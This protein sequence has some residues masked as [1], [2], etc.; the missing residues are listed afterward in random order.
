M[1][2]TFRGT[3]ARHLGALA[4]I[5]AIL[6]LPQQ[7]VAAQTTP[8]TGRLIGRV[9]DAINGTPLGDVGVQ[10]VGT[11]L[12]AITGADGRYTIAGVPAGTV[13]IHARRIGFQAKTVTAIRL[14]AGETLEQNVALREA[15][16][17]LT[18]V[19]VTAAA[20]RGT[21]RE[22][23]NQ[24]REATGIVNAVTA[25]QIA[26][27][28]D[29][30]AASAVQR[31]TGVTLQD[32]R[33]VYVRGMGE[34]Y[35]T[36]S[37]NGARMPSPEPEKKVVP[38][39]LFP[40]SLLR[41]V[42]T[43]KT[44][45]PDQPGD[46]SGAQVD[47]RT[48]EF[49]ARRTVTYSMSTG[50]NTRATGRDV[51][52]AP[53]ASSEWFAF[54]GAGRALPASVRAAG[55]FIGTTYSQAEINQMIG[56]FRNSWTPIS[57]SGLPNSS[58]GVSAGGN[59]P[60]FGRQIGY[61]GSFTYSLS[62]EIQDDDYRAQV[63]LGADDPTLPGNVF[64]GT[65]GR[66]GVQW[67]GLINLSTFLGEGTLLTFNNTFNRTADSEA[68]VDRGWDENIG[69]STVFERSTLRYIER[70]V[71]SHQ[72]AAEHMLGER[73]RVDWAL[74]SSAVTRAEPDRSD[75]V[76]ASFPDVENGGSTPFLLYS[77]ADAGARRTFADLAEDAWEASVNYR[78]KL[79]DETRDHSVKLGA[80]AR[81]TDR[82]A[83]VLQ[84]A[85][86]GLLRASDA[87]LPAEQIFDGRFTGADDEAFQLQPLGQ[88]GSYRARDRLAAG[89]VM[90]DWGLSERIRLVGGVR[91]ERSEVTVTTLNRLD[92]RTPSTRTF[93]DYLPSAALNIALTE[94][95]NLRL[96]LSQTLARPEYRELSPILHRD[97]LFSVAVQGNPELR[98]ALIRNADVRWE[99]YPAA[100]EV[101]SVA[102]FAKHFEDPVERVET[103]TS[104]TKIHSYVN[105]AGAANYGLE[106]E[107]RL[108]LGRLG[109]SLDPLTVFANTT[110]MRSRIEIG[111]DPL[112]ATTNP[113][114]AMV[115]QAP[116][117]VNAG[118]TWAPGDGR[119]S[120]TALYNVVGRRIYAAGE[121]E[122]PLAFDLVELPRAAVDVSL[123]A[124]LWNAVDVKLDARNLLDSPYRRTAGP[125][126]NERFVSGRTITIGFTWRPIGS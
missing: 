3:A 117:V 115:G 56:G 119:F 5:A 111:D 102:M 20:E 101:L 43:S 108:G 126:L 64:R 42:T 4:L 12:G 59:D 105:A 121:R 45:T 57:R 83:E 98:R 15:A 103:P 37:L 87:S 54:A 78:I 2:P 19:E 18:A 99:W 31:V 44:F 72:L 104:G 38:L 89:F 62:Q 125:I 113:D 123:R 74:T 106:L 93:T 48:R 6:C 24:Q 22:A 52:A 82:D 77:S 1:P 35:T 13:T 46:F 97:V 8:A 34:R 21:V 109:E 86:V 69:R 67:G 10:V 88:S 16:V 107:T 32:N 85:F 26:R 90:A 70:S 25:E 96:S 73:H 39:D 58:F 36:T 66:T 71:R 51:V 112:A 81:A 120:A 91:V 40:A 63:D 76:Y 118:A 9:V 116:Y 122:G 79:G 14:S 53:V 55:S 33:F 61:I 75:L 80:L 60:L 94:R 28:P 29:G 7:R 50:I 30:D 124:P 23:L 110:L 41:S 92:Q 17:T 27:S 100:G 49:P 65:T 114:R 95:Q 68:R 84:Y 47:I 11:T